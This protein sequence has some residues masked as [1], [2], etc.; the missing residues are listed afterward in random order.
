MT[1]IL[2]LADDP[3]FVYDETFIRGLHYMMLAYDLKKNARKWRPGGVMIQRDATGEI[4]YE[5]PNPELV[6]PL[7]SEL[8][9]QLRK[10]TGEPP[11]VRAAMA[12]LNL[13][14]IHPFSDGNG[15]MARAVQTLVTVREEKGVLDKEF[16]SIEEY[17]GMVRE[18]Y[19][20]VLSGV[21]GKTWN[22]SGDARPFLRFCLTAHLHQAERLL[23]RSR[24]LD[25]IWGEIEAEVRKRKLPERVLLALADAAMGFAVRNATYRPMVGINEHLASR[26]LKLLVDEGLLLPEGENRGRVYHACDLLVRIRQQAR[27]AFPLPT[28]TDP[29]VME[30]QDLFEVGSAASPTTHGRPPAQLPDALGD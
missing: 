18:D 12:H 13:V 24:R 11:I 26:D 29:F 2:Q 16:C 7:M 17:L 20:S 5:G 3:Y 14:M 25:R 4:V 21:G 8:V 30:Q 19:Y 15:R 9:A 6:P 10:Q 22:P 23:R 28:I 27:E 1:Y